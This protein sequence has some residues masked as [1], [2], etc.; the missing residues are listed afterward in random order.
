[1]SGQILFPPFTA[2][3]VVGSK[4]EGAV[5]VVMLRPTMKSPGTVKT[6]AIDILNAA[7]AREEKW[8]LEEERE[9]KQR[10]AESAQERLAQDLSVKQRQVKWNQ[11]MAEVRLAA[12]RRQTTAIH[13]K[14]VEQKREDARKVR[15]RP[16]KRRSLDVSLSS[17]TALQ[18]WEPVA[19]G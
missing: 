7:R 3:E 11:S 18:A 5:V 6:G 12:S 9:A 13:G 16:P 1:M 19:S 4:V 14:L 10:A 17:A 8:L 2:L 15:R